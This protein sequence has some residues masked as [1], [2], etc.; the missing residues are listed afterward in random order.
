MELYTIV[1][2]LKDNNPHKINFG[3]VFVEDVR[4]KT[5]WDNIVKSK[6]A[7][8]E[9][10]TQLDLFSNFYF[11]FD[12]VTL[13]NV[14]VLETTNKESFHSVTFTDNPEHK[15][16]SPISFIINSPQ[17]DAV[18]GGFIKIVTVEEAVKNINSVEFKKQHPT[19]IIVAKSVSRYDSEGNRFG[20]DKFTIMMHFKW[21]AAKPKGRIFRSDN[22]RETI[23]SE[24]HH[25]VLTNLIEIFSDKILNALMYFCSFLYRT[26]CFVVEE[27]FAEKRKGK[28]R[29][30]PLSFYRVID[31]KTLRKCYIKR[32]NNGGNDGSC[33]VA[34][35]ERRRH[36]R[37]FRSDYYKNRKGETII[38]EPIWIGPI[39][40]YDPEKKRMYKVLL[41][42]G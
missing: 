30:N 17:Q 20:E 3:H 29:V 6:L 23:I 34:P 14:N 38:I 27:H 16:T 8:N 31:I 40:S 24:Q 13:L 5:D 12:R 26:D 33:K 9:A 7:Q 10:L 36:T 32:E 42:I 39:E 28:L 2:R 35:H 37:T 25:T 1:K 21:M 19:D 15:T 11:P 18:F 22:I 4:D 41:N